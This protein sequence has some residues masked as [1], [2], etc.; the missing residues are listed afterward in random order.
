[1]NKDTLTIRWA[2]KDRD[3]ADRLER[4]AIGTGVSASTL[5]KIAVGAMLDHA[6]Q[7]GDPLKGV[8]LSPE[9]AQVQKRVEPIAIKTGVEPVS[10]L[11]MVVQALER[12]QSRGD[13]S[14]PISIGQSNP[15]RERII[16]LLQEVESLLN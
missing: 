15:S 4:L 2:Q 8:M 7:G 3:M 1:M 13:L 6:A 16:A 10:L 5:A 12:A 14:L 9:F 11:S